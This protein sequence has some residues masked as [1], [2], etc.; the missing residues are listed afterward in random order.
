MNIPY[1]AVILD[2]CIDDFIKKVSINKS[3]NKMV[4]N[5]IEVESGSKYHFQ[6]KSHSGKSEQN[7]R[8]QLQSRKLNHQ[9]K[10]RLLKQKIRAC[11]F[12]SLEINRSIETSSI[13]PNKNTPSHLSKRVK[14]KLDDVNMSK[15]SARK[16]ALIPFS[17]KNNYGHLFSKR[18]LF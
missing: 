3:Y 7:M 10:N 13:S 18:K 6:L 11:R 9:Y 2:T 1:E 14:M 8:Q 12:P 5:K 17:T 15:D 4:D 16:I